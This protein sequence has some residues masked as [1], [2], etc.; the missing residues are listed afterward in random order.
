LLVVFSAS[1]CASSADPKT[2]FCNNTKK[3]HAR[4]THPPTD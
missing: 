1:S 4:P 3:I 2:L